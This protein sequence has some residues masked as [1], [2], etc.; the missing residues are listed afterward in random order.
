MK[1]DL[2]FLNETSDLGK[3][4][5]KGGNNYCPVHEMKGGRKIPIHSMDDEHIK[6]TINLFLNM[7][8]DLKSRALNEVNDNLDLFEMELNGFE[9]VDKKKAIGQISSI[10]Y[11]LQPYIMEMV[12]RN[13]IDYLSNIYKSLEMILGRRDN[14]YYLN[15]LNG[16]L[17]N[18]LLG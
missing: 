14:K 13:R 7:C 18:E 3:S 8:K 9:P 4:K 12:I 1:N 11:N 17:D 16:E 15:K 2:D 10:M 6:N 5:K